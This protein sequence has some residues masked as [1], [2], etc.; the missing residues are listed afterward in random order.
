M[1]FIDIFN[2]GQRIAV[3]QKQVRPAVLLKHGGY[4]TPMVDLGASRAAAR[5]A[6]QISRG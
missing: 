1:S 5:A 6:Y 3:R 4:S 2:E